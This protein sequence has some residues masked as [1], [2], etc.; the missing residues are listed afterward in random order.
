MNTPF[1]SRLIFLDSQYRASGTPSNALFTFSDFIKVPFNNIQLIMSL[2]DCQISLSN[3]N[4]DDNSNTLIYDIGAGDV[5]VT[6]TNGNYSA[7]DIRDHI[8]TLQ[9][10]LTFAYNL[11]TNKFTITAV[12]DFTIRST[13]KSL[14]EFGF[15]SADHTSVSSTLTSDSVCDLS[16]VTSIY[17]I[18]NNFS[19]KSLDSRTGRHTTILDKIAV[20]VEAN[21]VLSY[22]NNGFKTA[23]N[24][25]KISFIEIVLEDQNRNE[26][27]FNS[28]E[29][30]WH[31]S[32]QVDFMYRPSLR[33]DDLLMLNYNKD[34]K[35]LKE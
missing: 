35:D 5:T 11:I 21:G 13:S 27:D 4:I 31:M 28:I 14:R 19:T 26:L 34:E 16:G 1:P 6:M 20:D 29:N 23:V 32:L 33:V 10:D 17:V 9:T 24:E 12:S 8:N 25:S 15:T 30:A 7:Y 2:K 22:E 18:L 3:Y